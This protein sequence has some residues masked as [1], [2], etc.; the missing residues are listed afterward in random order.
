MRK[1]DS[2]MNGSCFFSPIDSILYFVYGQMPKAFL[3]N[4]HFLEPLDRCF[5]LSRSCCCCCRCCCCLLFVVEEELAL[6]SEEG[7][8]MN[9]RGGRR[10]LR[11]LSQGKTEP[12]SKWF[13]AQCT[14]QKKASDIP[15]PSRDV[16]YQT[17][18]GRE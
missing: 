15:A 17:L 7:L 2:N 12:A 4:K 18:P 10:D 3:H 14:L 5:L 9:P 13:H 16:T 8:R 1:I 11:G 6:Y